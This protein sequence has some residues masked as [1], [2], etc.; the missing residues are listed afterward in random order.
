MPEY[1][2]PGVYVEEVSYRAKSIQGLGTTTTGFIGPTRYGPVDI[3]PDIITSIGEF[4][5]TYGDRQQMQFGGPTTMPNFMWHA[6]R[7]FFE[8]GGTKLYVSRV[9]TPM[10]TP[11]AGDSTDG[12][13][14]YT[15]TSP[16]TSINVQARF[17][18]EFGN[19]HVRITL[20]LGE[21]VLAQ[22]VSTG[23][24]AA[25]GLYDNDVVALLFRA[26]H[27]PVSPPLSSQQ[28]VVL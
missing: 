8:E 10:A 26:V 7:A 4:E 1:L 14:A 5:R 15:I 3:P 22:D 12:K 25:R 9:F 13:A 18:G 11:G 17:A 6:A 21:N 23:R 28:R 24:P 16:G 27:S 19:M 2:S 20:R